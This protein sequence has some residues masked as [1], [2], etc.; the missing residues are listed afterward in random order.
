MINDENNNNCL[1][2]SEFLNESMINKEITKEYSLKSLKAEKIISLFKRFHLKLEMLK[3]LI[4]VKLC[5]STILIQAYTKGFLLRKTIKTNIII[6]YLLNLREK[7]AKIIQNKYRN[8]FYIK[9]FNN[10]LEKEKSNYS[11]YFLQ[12]S[13]SKNIKFQILTSV[14]DSQTYNFEFCPSRKINVCYVPKKNVQPVPYLC[15]F[16]IDNI[17]VLDS[18]YQTVYSGKTFYNKIDFSLFEKVVDSDGEEEDLV[19]TNFVED[20]KFFN[21]K[22]IEFFRKKIEKDLKK[23]STTSVSNA[24]KKS[25]SNLSLSNLRKAEISKNK[26]IQ[27]V[28]SMSELLQKVPLKPILKNKKF[29]NIINKKA[30]VGIVDS[31]TLK[32]S[33]SDDEVD[34][35]KRL[36][37]LENKSSFALRPQIHKKSDEN[38]SSYDAE[39]DFFN[40]KN[41]YCGSPIK[42]NRFNIIKR[43]SLNLKNVEIME[44]KC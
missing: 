16:I 12:N 23:C 6:N 11:I 38:D 42:N 22:N 33:E 18:R 9:E 7:C 17:P 41:G 26:K 35:K 43:V 27:Y 20:S 1:M 8:Y 29:T 44:Y 25:N 4:F 14:N 2:N 5:K 15:S 31:K 24:F 13:Y 40:D 32:V 30:V 36:S 19:E 10:I 3:N 39:D 34:V 28:K 21:L 37:V